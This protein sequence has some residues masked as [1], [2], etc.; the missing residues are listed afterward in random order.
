MEGFKKK[1]YTRLPIEWLTEACA[2][3]CGGLGQ[4]R[5]IGTIGEKFPSETYLKV[6]MKLGMETSGN[7]LET[8]RETSNLISNVGNFLESASMQNGFF[9]NL[10]REK[11]ESKLITIWK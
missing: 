8:F 1:F 9:F 5:G 6:S 11:S 10:S 4:S 7:L 2:Q 3:G